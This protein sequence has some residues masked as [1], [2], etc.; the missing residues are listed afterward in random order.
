MFQPNSIHQI[1]S[2][3]AGGGHPHQGGIMLSGGGT[4]RL[5]RCYS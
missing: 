4:Q 3:A 2:T 1:E 5:N